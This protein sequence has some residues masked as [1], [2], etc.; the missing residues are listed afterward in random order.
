MIGNSDF[1]FNSCR[2]RVFGR[3][4]KG[5]IGRDVELGLRHF[6]LIYYNVITAVASL[7]MFSVLIKELD[8]KKLKQFK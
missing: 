2:I 7:V 6:V 8:I 5:L 4:R 1:I 3:I